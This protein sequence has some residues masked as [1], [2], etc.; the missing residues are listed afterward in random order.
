MV[1]ARGDPLPAPF[2]PRPASDLR[3]RA[4][5]GSAVDVI[6]VALAEPGGTIFTG[7][8][9]DIAALAAHTRDISVELI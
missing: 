9:A 1:P 5:T 7:D 4:R 2:G 8:K 3:R 6:V